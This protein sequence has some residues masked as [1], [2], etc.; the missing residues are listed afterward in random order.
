MHSVPDNRNPVIRTFRIS[1][2]GVCPDNESPDNGDPD[3][4]DPDNGSPDNGNGVYK[5]RYS[6]S[7]LS[8]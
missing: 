6:D 4:G 8:G 1:G 5:I 3:N 2:N 7:T